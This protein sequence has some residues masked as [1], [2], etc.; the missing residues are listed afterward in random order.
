VPNSCRSRRAELTRWLNDTA[1]AADTAGGATSDAGAA[2]AEGAD[3]AWQAVTAALADY[4][5]KARDIDG[6]IGYALVGALRSA[7]EAI[8]DFVKTGKLDLPLQGR[9][10]TGH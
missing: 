1:T 10:M 7:E 5:A 9:V 2:A 4:A 8:G 3:T 6:N